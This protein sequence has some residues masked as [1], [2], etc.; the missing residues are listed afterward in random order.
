MRRRQYLAWSGILLSAIAGCSDNSEEINDAQ[1]TTT[2]TESGAPTQTEAPTETEDTTETEATTETE[3]PT[4]TEETT[5]TEPAGEADVQFGER[6]LVKDDSGFSTEAYAE[7]IVENVGDGAAGQIT[8]DVEWYDADG[9]FLDND[10][11]R[12]PS[13]EAGEVWIAQVS[14]LTTDAEDIDS[15]E[16]SGEFEDSSPVQPKDMRVRESEL[17]VEDYS[18][19]IT[20]VAENNREDEMD[21]VEA[22]GKIYDEQ[23]RVIGGGW[24]NETDIPAGTNWKFEIP[25]AGRSRER[26]SDAADHV[27]FLDAD[28]F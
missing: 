17:E 18:A 16:V 15:I 19:Q 26:A 4:E 10:T 27:A 22:H 8:V 2:S 20:G 3:D 13:L 1:D 14:A 9:N 28:L 11:G 7:V 25:L 12:L 24:T 5:Q 6:E 23:D 21:Y